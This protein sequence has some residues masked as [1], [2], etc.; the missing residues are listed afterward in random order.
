MDDAAIAPVRLA[1]LEARSLW[2][3]WRQDQVRGVG[4]QATGP[5][6]DA[7]LAAA[8]RQQVAVERVVLVTKKHRL[9]PV[10]ALDDKAGD[11]GQRAG[12]HLM[13]I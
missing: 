3:R 2:R 1:Q 5:D 8:R 12:W 10:A 4:H 13:G 11:A 7:G 6:L 9:P